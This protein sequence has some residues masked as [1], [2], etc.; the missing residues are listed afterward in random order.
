MELAK[1][2]VADKV[3]LKISHKT[4]TIFARVNDTNTRVQNI[5]MTL[6][7]CTL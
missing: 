3:K 6:A 5:L 4:G 2:G 7:G 1:P